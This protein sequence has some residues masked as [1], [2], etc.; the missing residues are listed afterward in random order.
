MGSARRGRFGSHTAMGAPSVSAN[1]AIRP[2]SNT[3][4]GSVMMVAP[5]AAAR[6]AVSSA[7]STQK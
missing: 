7:L 3:S 4:K 5:A 6:A 2:A 1:I